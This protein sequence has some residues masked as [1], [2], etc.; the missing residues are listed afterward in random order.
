MRDL[1][2]W[3]GLSL[4]VQGL[5]AAW[6]WRRIPRAGW[7][8]VHWGGNGLQ[9][10]GWAPKAVG[11]LITPAMTLFILAILAL[12]SIPSTPLSILP[13]AA[14]MLVL[15]AVIAG[16][17]VRRAAVG[18]PVTSARPEIPP[19]DLPKEMPKPLSIITVTNVSLTTLLA[20]Q[21]VL[22]IVGWFAIPSGQVAIHFTGLDGEPDGYA[23]KP[24]A[25]AIMP[26]VTLLAFGVTR[27]LNPVRT[28]PRR[29][30]FEGVEIF[31]AI[32]LTAAHAY[33]VFNAL[34]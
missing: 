8:P 15:Q 16:V 13:G 17:G 21:V 5:L 11:L 18:P 31:I 4:L 3:F 29:P 22:S 14:L 9:P 12:R 19:F 33:I 10:D 28:E 24:F 1:L 7:V 27:L 20:C 25:L 32:A 26:L 2:V 23:S 30:G 34:T 6:A